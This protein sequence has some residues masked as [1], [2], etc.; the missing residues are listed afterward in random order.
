MLEFF[1]KDTGKGISKKNMDTVFHRFT[2]IYDDSSLF[3]E[4]T[5]LGLAIS[6]SLVNLLGGKVW[7]ESEENK[8]S[9]FYFNIPLVESMPEFSPKDSDK[10]TKR[11]VT[12]V[13]SNRTILVV[14]DEEL[15]FYLLKKV[16]EDNG[17]TLLR[18]KN[19]IK[20]V[21]ISK[22]AN[23][24]LILMDIKMPYM[25]G[26]DATREIRRF[27]KTIPIIAQTAY[28]LEGEKE[29]CFEAG[30]TDY[31]A[32]PIIKELLLQKIDEVFHDLQKS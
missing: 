17:A 21:E 9:T 5:G 30:C 1:V 25:N 29:Q 19:G 31:I 7:V 13:L 15:N 8:G 23:I 4:G 6:Q 10:I 26:L 12:A 27:N 2:Q 11:D 14:E 32:K 28:A 20:A 16:L 18:S 22:T 3:N 24:D